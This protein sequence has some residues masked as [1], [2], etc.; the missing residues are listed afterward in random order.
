MAEC[1][2][3]VETYVAAVETSDGETGIITC[4]VVCRQFVF[5]ESVVW[6]IV[7]Y[8]HQTCSGTFSQFELISIRNRLCSWMTHI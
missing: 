3:H 4:T 6:E 5:C 1:V 2:E 7:P 8:I